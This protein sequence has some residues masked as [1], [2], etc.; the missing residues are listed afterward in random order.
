MEYTEPLLLQHQKHYSQGVF[1]VALL[2]LEV[3]LFLPFWWIAKHPPQGVWDSDELH[4]STT[5]CLEKCTQFETNEFSLSLGETASLNREARIIGY[6]SAVDQEDSC[7]QVPKEFREYLHIMVKKTAEVLPA[8]RP[9]NYKIDLQE[10][11]ITPWGPIYPLSENELQ[12]FREWLKEMLRW[13]KIQ[14]STSSAGSPI[15]FVPKPNGRGLRLCVNH[16]ALN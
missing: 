3:D 12:N 13:G 16:R 9:Y 10:G 4:F 6:V 1:E 5:S 14:R 2:E 11:E 8:Q 7:D 15:L